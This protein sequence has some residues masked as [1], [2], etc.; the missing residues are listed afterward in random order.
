MSKNN[1]FY[2]QPKHT[3]LFN[4]Y[5]SKDSERIVKIEVET[6]EL[7]LI[8]VEFWPK[9][10]RLHVENFRPLYIIFCCDKRAL[11]LYFLSALF[12]LKGPKVLS[13]RSFKQIIKLLLF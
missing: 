11:Q 2:C 10:G 8:K 12:E 5:L 3:S 9:N 4:I 6:F 1:K 13:Q 7:H